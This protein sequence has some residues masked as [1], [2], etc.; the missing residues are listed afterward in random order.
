MTKKI[1][2]IQQRPSVDVVFYEPTESF[3]TLKTEFIN[4]GKMKETITT[5]S[6][7]GLTRS[8]LAEWT[9]LDDYI[10][11]VNDD[12]AIE[13]NN[14]RNSHNETNLISFSLEDIEWL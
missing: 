3:G 4:A 11:F 13:N 2:L 8:T 6:E 1:K 10:N 5:I 9:T 14:L 12:R 7:D